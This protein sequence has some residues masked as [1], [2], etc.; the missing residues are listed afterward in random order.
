MANVLEIIN[1][2][3]HLR[4]FVFFIKR[5]RHHNLEAAV[6]KVFTI[7]PLQ[8]Y[9]KPAYFCNLSDR[10]YLH[11]APA[12]DRKQRN[13]RS[14]RQIRKSCNMVK[15]PSNAAKNFASRKSPARSDESFRARGA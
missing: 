15:I 3:S 12:E 5:D 2:I 14:M 13:R 7:P 6:T 10:E 11:L 9:A 1:K 8:S 4:S